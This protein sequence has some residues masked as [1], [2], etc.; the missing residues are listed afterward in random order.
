MTGSQAWGSSDWTHHPSNILL[1]PMGIVVDNYPDS[2]LSNTTMNLTTPPT[3]VANADGRLACLDNTC[4]GLTNASC[5]LSSNG[6]INTAK[7]SITRVQPFIGLYDPFWGKL[8]T[9]SSI[10]K[11]LSAWR[12][13]VLSWALLCC[14]F[15]LMCACQSCGMLRHFLFSVCRLRVGRASIRIVQRVQHCSA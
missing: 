4:R 14:T 1:P 5:Y 7:S 11:G 3:Q 12:S 6:D 15:H 9:V 13:F 8:A 2:W 10:C